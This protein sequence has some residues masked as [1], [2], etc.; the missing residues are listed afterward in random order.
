[1]GKHGAGELN[2]S[3]DIDLIVSFR[4]ELLAVP[5][6]REPLEAAV[7]ITKDVVRV[8][9]EQ[10]GGGYVFRTDLRLRPDPAS[11]PIA[12]PVERAVSYYQT[13]GQNWERAALIIKA[14]PIAGL[15]ASARPSSTSSRPSSGGAIS[16]MPRSPTSMR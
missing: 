16:I 4:P 1:M 15:S 9:H 14:R 5:A 12:V 3:S 11:T 6:G 13:V 8:L 10:T 2:Y 7:R